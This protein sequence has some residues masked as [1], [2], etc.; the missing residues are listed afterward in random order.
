MESSEE[1]EILDEEWKHL[2]ESILD[3]VV[4]IH[5]Q[6]FGSGDL[7]Q[8]VSLCS[9]YFFISSNMICKLALKVLYALFC[10]W[11]LVI[12]IIKSILV[13][14]LCDIS[15]CAFYPDLELH[16]MTFIRPMFDHLFSVVVRPSV[17]VLIFIF[18]CSFFWY[19]VVIWLYFFSPE[20]SKFLMKIGCIPS[21]SH[22]NWVSI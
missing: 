9:L 10:Y 2:E 15:F 13:N 1:C 3:N 22:I 5:N 4:L 16:C 11:I 7:V 20:S 14:V 19:L 8:A 12:N 17:L 6:L 21:A 18:I